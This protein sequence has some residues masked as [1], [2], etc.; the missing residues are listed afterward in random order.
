MLISPHH[1]LFFRVGTLP[2]LNPPNVEY[3]AN[4]LK[5]LEVLRIK[6]SIL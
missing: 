1:D 6:L 4:F 3:C 2:D 5:Y